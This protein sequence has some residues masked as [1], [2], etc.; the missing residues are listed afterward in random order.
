MTG[1]KKAVSLI[2]CTM[3]FFSM[4]AFS[5][6]YADN[7]AQQSNI[8][9]ESVKYGDVF[10]DGV[11]DMQDVLFV[12]KHV[13]KLLVLS[14]NPALAAD[15]DANSKIDMSDVLYIQK[16]VAKYFNK[17]PAEDIEQPTK[18]I[19]DK[20]G[21]TKIIDDPEYTE[22][23]NHH[24]TIVYTPPGYTEDQQYPVIYAH[25]GQ[26]LF[27]AE[28]SAYGHW[29]LL[30]TLDQLINDGIIEPVIMVGIYNNANRLIEYSPDDGGDEYLDYIADGV[31]PYID[32]H[33]STKTGA[34]N[35]AIMGSSM[36]GLISLYA[37]LRNSD[38][39]GKAGVI[40]PSIWYNDK[41]ILDSIASM[42]ELPNTKFWIDA[43]TGETAGVGDQL[44]SM[45]QNA[46]DLS[47]LLMEKGAAPVDDFLYY[48]VPK[49]GHN[50]ASWSERV[51]MTLTYFFGTEPITLEDVD[52][53]ASITSNIE[54]LSLYPIPA[55][56]C[57]TNVI[58]TP[59]WEP[60]TLNDP[61]GIAE[62]I[63]P[64][65]RVKGNSVGEV[66]VTYAAFE[67]SATLA[68]SFIE[69]VP[70]TVTFIVTVPEDTPADAEISIVGNLSV[71][72]GWNPAKGAPMERV[73]DTHFTCTIPLE[74][75]TS[76]EYKYVKGGSWNGG[77]KNAT[78][79]EIGNRT[80]TVAGIV[81]IEDTVARWAN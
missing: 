66:T 10:E 43:G 35:T 42:E 30:E 53:L 55:V 34:E 18:P 33:Y 11:V 75:G 51:N 37:G 39:F 63:Q 12:Q 69:D 27:Y 5:I 44:G 60:L 24:T 14:D 25:D 16:Y 70:I 2:L 36:G 4:F 72:G 46:R 1:V 23:E 3:I 61:D 32:A 7:S 57:K 28:T 68:L 49:A 54:G 9:K 38:T 79:G 40:S 15:V 20:E 41:S 58:Y 17:F 52:I 73:D 77:E 65:N 48:E 45:V 50:E 21:K 29:K 81:T 13:A 80:H 26:N 22:M 64:G 47:A 62:L 56:I 71:F 74:I 6:V 78:G 8:E 67:K 59:V 19:E 31:K 76:M